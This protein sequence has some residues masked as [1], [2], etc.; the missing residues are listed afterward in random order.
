MANF[1]E[2]YLQNLSIAGLGSLDLSQIKTGSIFLTLS[3]N[4]WVT[5]SI[6]SKLTNQD[7][8][9][10]KNTDIIYNDSWDAELL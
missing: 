9:Y 2:G 10:E 1:A 3:G 8:G 4:L 5:D 6:Y 7:A